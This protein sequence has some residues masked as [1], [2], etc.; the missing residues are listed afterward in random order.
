M[1]KRKRGRPRKYPEAFTRHQQHREREIE[2]YDQ[3]LV[4][5]T[6]PWCWACGRGTAYADRPRD[7]FGPWLIERA[8]I[9]N[10][11]RRCD[12]RS[13]VLLCSACH[14]AGHHQERIRIDGEL[15]VRIELEH[16]LWMKRERDP[17]YYDRAF[18]QQQSVR[19]LPM[20]RKLG[21]FYLRQYQQRRGHCFACDT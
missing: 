8:H 21:E 13:V 11:P 15:L 19:I 6:K 14:K 4:E 16:M 5:I 12:R 1:L 3:M 20:A 2:R 17:E 7:W 10:K 18:L 9:V